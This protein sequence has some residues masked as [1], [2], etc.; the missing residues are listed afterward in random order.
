[1]D[2]VSTPI[3]MYPL[4]TFGLKGWHQENSRVPK[5]LPMIE[6]IN[7]RELNIPLHVLDL[8]L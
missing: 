5:R 4:K 6:L 8:E 3:S 1:M 7:P 2:S